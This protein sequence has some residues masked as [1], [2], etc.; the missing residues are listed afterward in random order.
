MFVSLSVLVLTMYVRVCYF[1]YNFR[2]RCSVLECVTV[3]Y[4]IRVRYS[5]LECVIVCVLDTPIQ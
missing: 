1:F 3:C 2:V 4:D 5:V